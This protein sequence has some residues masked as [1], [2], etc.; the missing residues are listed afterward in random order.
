MRGRA[1]AACLDAE[2]RLAPTAIMTGD[3]HECQVRA[4]G[5]RMHPQGAH[6]CAA[7]AACQPPPPAACSL[8]ETHQTAGNQGSCVPGR[9][10]GCRGRTGRAWRL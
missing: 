7:R 1:L 3:S 10:A 2:T 4:R 8:F 6:L 9:L 5:R